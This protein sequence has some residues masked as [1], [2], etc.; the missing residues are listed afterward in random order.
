MAAAS[1]LG[2]SVQ[3]VHRCRAAA[4]LVVDHAAGGPVRVLTPT[5]RRNRAWQK[6]QHLIAPSLFG[7]QLPGRPWEFDLERLERQVRLGPP[8]SEWG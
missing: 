5:E 1:V 6:R 2:V 8:A 3:T 4:T 7:Q